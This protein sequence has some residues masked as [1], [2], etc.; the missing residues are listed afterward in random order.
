MAADNGIIV[1]EE[2]LEYV[3]TQVDIEEYAEWLGMQLP[4]D[5]DYLWIAE[6]GLK[7]ALPSEWVVCLADGA[8]AQGAA[9]VFFFNRTTGESTWEHPCD[10]YYRRLFQKEKA[11][12]EPRL[13]VTLHS[14]MVKPGALEVSAL[15]MGG[16]ALATLEVSSPYETLQVFIH[17]LKKQLNEKVRVVLPDG[18]ILTKADKKVPISELLGMRLRN[19]QYVSEGSQSNGSTSSSEADPPTLTTR[20]CTTH[21][22]KPHRIARRHTLPAGAKL[23][24]RAELPPLRRLDKVLYNMASGTPTDGR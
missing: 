11:R 7:S 24:A 5:R 14:I 17:R 19:E 13:I 18:R 22:P 21:L 12:N 23:T 4:E 2:D 16:D 9:E 8:E 15:N 1:L 3:S 6:K 10:E 20:S